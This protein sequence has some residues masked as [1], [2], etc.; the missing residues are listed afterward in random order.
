VTGAFLSS[1]LLTARFPAAALCLGL[2]AGCGPVAYYGQAVRG[3][4]ALLAASTPI[5][6]L[7]VEPDTPEALRQRLQTVTALRGF[8]ADVLG[9]PAGGSFRSYAAI[10]RRY[11]AWTV[12]ATPEFSLEAKTWCF[13]VAG[14]V[15]YRGYFDPGEA[16]RFAAG[17]RARGYDVHVAGVPAYSTLGWLRDPL[18]STVI[19]W[20]EAD[21]AGLVFH[22][23]AHQRLYVRDDT[24]FNEGFAVAVEQAGVYRWL[25]RH[26]PPGAAE[27]Y[28]EAR[29]R[30]AACARLALDGRDRLEDLYR[31]TLPVAEL[32]RL[33]EEAFGAL[34]AR[35]GE[36]RDREG[37]DTRCAPWFDPTPNNARLAAVAAYQALVPGFQSLLDAHGG[38]LRAFYRAAD[39]L[40]RLPRAERRERLAAPRDRP[41]DPSADRA[42]AMRGPQ[43]QAASSLTQPS[44]SRAG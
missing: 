9:L 29:E 3:Q 27:A 25:A 5:E 36:L 10:D 35:Y 12:V 16:D 39:A 7:L 21:L 24:A 20:P 18:P 44:G 14:C 31:L 32:R 34:H 41:A 22:E 6:T 30:R 15:A 38:D 4:L 2:A 33:K 23:L 26:G 43:G 42:P 17:L 8:A 37:G 11:V 40:S 19:G 1:A 28:R 13:P